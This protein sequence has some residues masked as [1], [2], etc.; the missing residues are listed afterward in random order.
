MFLYFCF[1]Y[2]PVQSVKVLA[3]GSTAGSNV[4]GNSDDISANAASANSGG[5]LCATV[6][7]V[8]ICSAAKAH[9]VDHRL[10]DRLLKTTYYEPQLSALTTQAAQPP[11]SHYSGSASQHLHRSDHY[12]SAPSQSP[13]QLGS[14]SPRF[15]SR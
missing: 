10:E 8:D 1:R 5:G 13:Q 6:A 14:R 12:S 15:T 3:S 2:G 7:F 4:G 9:K 11:S